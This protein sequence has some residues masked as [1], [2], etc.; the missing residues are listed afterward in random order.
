VLLLGVG[1][2]FGYLVL[3]SSSIVIATASGLLGA[4]FG[5]M[6]ARR[7][8][9]ASWVDVGEGEQRSPVHGYRSPL[10][11]KFVCGL[12]AEGSSHVVTGVVERREDEVCVGADGRGVE[13]HYGAVIGTGALESGI[14]RPL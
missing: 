4:A 7:R 3:A 1:T 8:A 6:V 5:E 10:I 14:G 12:S 13:P 11:A 9:A 2:A